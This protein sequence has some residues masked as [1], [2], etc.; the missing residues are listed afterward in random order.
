MKD[1]FILIFPEIFSGV[2]SHIDNDFS[3]PNKTEVSCSTI[4]GRIETIESTNNCNVFPQR[5]STI[6]FHEFISSLSLENF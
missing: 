6:K 4:S 1:H 2:P 3:I 5:S